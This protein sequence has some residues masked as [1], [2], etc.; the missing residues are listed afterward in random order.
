[1]PIYCFT[2]RRGSK[3]PPATVERFFSMSDV[4]SSVR[5]PDGRRAYRDMVAERRGFKDTN[6]AGWPMLSDAL[7]VHPDQISDAR[8]EAE[9]AGV[10]LDFTR[11]GRAIL[12]SRTHRRAVLRALGYHDRNGG[13]SDG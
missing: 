2:T 3:R 6:G 5:L 1:M 12:E 4:P 10:R 8:A 11:D 9:R 13:Y 7:G